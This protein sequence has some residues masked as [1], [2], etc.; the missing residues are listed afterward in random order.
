MPD[1][2]ST[3]VVTRDMNALEQD[4][5][6]S[7]AASANHY[8]ADNRLDPALCMCDVTVAVSATVCCYQCRLTHAN[9]PAILFAVAVSFD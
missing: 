1:V 7:L 5:L 3:P 8:I 4:A 2:I 9:E 6:A